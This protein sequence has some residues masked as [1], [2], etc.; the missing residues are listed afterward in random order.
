[1]TDDR[2]GP[3][4]GSVR[5]F[6]ELAAS[7]SS[8]DHAGVTAAA[9]AIA[10]AFRT[11]N[12]VV[13]FGNGG[14][15]ADAQ[16]LAAEFVGRFSQDRSSLPAVALTADS[17]T[18]TS[19]ANDFGFE[20][21]FSRQLA[22]LGRAGDVAVGITTSGKSE[23][24][25]R[26]LE[27]ARASGIQSIALSSERDE[28]LERIVDIFLAVPASSTARIQE[29]HAL[30]RHMICETVDVLLSDPAAVPVH[31][32]GALG[33]DILLKRRA[34]WRDQGKVVVSTNGCFDLLHAGHVHMLTSARAMGDVLVVGLN[35][36]GT[37]R[38]LK[39]QGR[40]LLP[41]AERAEV[42]AS[43]RAVDAVVIFEEL[44]PVELLKALQPDIH[45]KGADYAPEVRTS[46]IPEQAVVEAGGGT[47][48]FV[49]LRESRSTSEIVR[50]ASGRGD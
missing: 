39:G 33:L 22:G 3:L 31:P 50:R 11:G 29:G 35:A 1:M 23:N 13:L 24:V 32:V 34:A 12:K 25:R 18:L 4:V 19:I 41:A 21:V 6:T 42:L 27:L 46:P 48:R 16:H 14:S 37:V 47:V 30:L 49:P 15:A 17:A 45:C 40:P 8:V 26:A 36:D 38:E 44:T 10:K 9:R 7:M 28:M 20:N 5:E 2:L 43:M